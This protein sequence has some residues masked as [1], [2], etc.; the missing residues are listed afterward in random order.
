[1]LIGGKKSN[2]FRLEIE[3]GTIFIPEDRMTY[4]NFRPIASQEIIAEMI[5]ILSRPPKKM[6]KRYLARTHQIHVI[7]SDNSL[8]D[9][10]RL[11]RDLYGR[12][13]VRTT[14]SVTESALLQKLRKRLVSEWA[15][16]SERDET[17]I[18]H[19]MEGLLVGHKG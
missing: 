11:V 5:E 15:V 6:D 13:K 16:A 7:M 17:D 10:A 4:E 3:N 9:M 18:Q 1:M 19:Q 12:R 8:L 2:Y 14:L